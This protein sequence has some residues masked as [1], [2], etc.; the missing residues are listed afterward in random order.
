MNTPASLQMIIS[1]AI[2]RLLSH[3]NLSA[4]RWEAARILCSG[5][6]CAK[7]YPAYTPFTSSTSCSSPKGRVSSCFT[8][9]LTFSASADD[10]QTV[11]TAV[12]PMVGFTLV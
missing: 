3:A 9:V 7:T 2:N 6:R 4:G 5:P 1:S 10:S 8:S 11:E 12:E